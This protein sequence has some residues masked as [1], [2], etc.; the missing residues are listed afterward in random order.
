MCPT[1][2][3]FIRGKPYG[4]DQNGIILVVSSGNRPLDLDVDKASKGQQSCGL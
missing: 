4:F 1:V 2:L 3:K